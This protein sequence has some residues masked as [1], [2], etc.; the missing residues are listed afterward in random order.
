MT[1]INSLRRPSGQHLLIEEIEE[2]FTFTYFLMPCKQRLSL[3]ETIRAFNSTFAGI[4]ETLQLYGLLHLKR[5]RLING[6]IQRAV[7]PL[8]EAK[9]PPLRNRFEGKWFQILQ[10]CWPRKKWNFNRKERRAQ[11]NTKRRLTYFIASQHQMVLRTCIPTLH[12][13]II[14]ADH[15]QGL[16]KSGQTR[17][18]HI[19]VFRST[20]FEYHW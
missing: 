16:V 18:S 19:Y 9:P 3:S 5:G 4:N 10:V 20:M 15:L 11:V 12:Q 14:R 2:C 6:P 7:H 8:F 1:I 17:V 13:W